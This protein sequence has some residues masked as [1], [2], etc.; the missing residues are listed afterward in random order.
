MEYI[1]VHSL[2]LKCYWSVTKPRRN[3]IVTSYFSY[4]FVSPKQNNK[5]MHFALTSPKSEWVSREHNYPSLRVFLL[6]WC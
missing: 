1:D 5:N 2:S 4:S 6:Q 3:K